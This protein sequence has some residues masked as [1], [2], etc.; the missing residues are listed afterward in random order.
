MSGRRPLATRLAG[1]LGVLGVLGLVLAGCGDGQGAKDAAAVRD[2]QGVVVSAGA[3]SVFDLR[4]GDCI[5][6]VADLE[7]DTA[8]VPLVPCDLP[9]QQEIFAVVRHPDDAY[10]GA[11]AVASF[12]DRSCLSALDTD[13]GLTIDDGVAFSYLLPTLEG[14][15]RSGDRTIVCVLVFDPAL[16]VTGSFVAGTADPAAFAPPKSD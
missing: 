10:P 2:A 7:G 6:D 11:G 5:G 14:W 3:W 15:N 8:D 1:R 9:H 13:L 16:G 4:P 12:A